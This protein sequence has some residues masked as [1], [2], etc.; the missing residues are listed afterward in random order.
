MGN[1]SDVDTY[2]LDMELISCGEA[3]PY[4]DAVRGYS[5]K[6]MAIDYDDE[7]KL[8]GVAS[9]HTLNTLTSHNPLMSLD[10]ISGELVE[11]GHAALYEGEEMLDEASPCAQ[12]FVFVDAFELMEEYRGKGYGPY[13]LAQC[14]S[15]FFDTYDVAVLKAFPFFGFEM[16]RET[17][18][19]A[20]R[21]ISKAWRSIGFKKIHG[22]VYAADIFTL[23]EKA[24][25]MKEP[26]IPIP[27]A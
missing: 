1:T 4:R 26:R 24:P 7:R 27:A 14:L 6:F 18:K 22:D 8:I 23:V 5:V 3:S 19:V 16:D 11:L 2:L 15:A 21:K 13:L 25:T 9:L 20:K 17:L 10:E 12:K